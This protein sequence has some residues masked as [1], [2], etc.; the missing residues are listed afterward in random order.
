M[1]DAPL[2]AHGVILPSREAVAPPR[3]GGLLWRISRSTNRLAL[4]LAGSRWNPIFSVVEHRGRRSGRAYRTPVAA[5]RV[6]DGFVI[7]L[8][9]GAW[10][11][12][13]RNLLAAGGG[14]IRWRGI[15]HPVSGPE[16]LDA[17]VGL[18]VFHPIQRWLLR[19]AGVHGYVHVRDAASTSR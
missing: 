16:V 4:P 10:V 17:D 13:Y 8:A 12:W 7:S 3:F 1:A 14:S 11:D 19:I 5:R 6:A 18:A 9:F 15:D 2:G